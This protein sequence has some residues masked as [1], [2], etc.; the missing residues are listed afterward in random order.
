MLHDLE[1]VNQLF[2]VLL[3]EKKNDEKLLDIFI[4]WR[5]KIQYYPTLLIVYHSLK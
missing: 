4:C 5:V 1:V 3:P 2:V